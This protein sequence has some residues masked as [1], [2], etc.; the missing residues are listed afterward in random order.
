V[1][2][3]G[4]VARKINAYTFWLENTTVINRL[5]TGADKKK[6]LK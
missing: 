4:R 6:T 5:Q 3:A 2:W 1:R